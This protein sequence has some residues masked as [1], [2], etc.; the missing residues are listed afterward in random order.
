[1][2]SAAAWPFCSGVSL[3]AAARRVVSRLSLDA[4]SEAETV[5]CI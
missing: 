4:A 2:R 5:A 3:A 1:M